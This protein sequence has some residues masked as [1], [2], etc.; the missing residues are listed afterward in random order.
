MNDWIDYNFVPASDYQAGVVNPNLSNIPISPSQPTN[1]F[2]CEIT[3]S[4][5]MNNAKTNPT[6]ENYISCQ[7]LICKNSVC[8]DCNIIECPSFTAFPTSPCPP[9]TVC[10]MVSPCPPQTVCPINK[11][12]VCP[13]PPS[14][15]QQTWNIV[16][17]VLSIALAL[18]LIT[19][20]IIFFKKAAPHPVNRF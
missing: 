11:C 16:L 17:L 14:F 7:N 9:Q 12:A 3:H 19:F 18:G 4:N 8:Q 13:S 1:C 20:L 10:P 2:E 15:F 6:L 5:C